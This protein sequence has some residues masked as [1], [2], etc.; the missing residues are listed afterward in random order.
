MSRAS[1]RKASSPELRPVL[2]IW[3]KKKSAISVISDIDDTIKITEI[4]AGPKVVVWNT[5]FR[6]FAAASGM[7]TMYQQELGA[8]A[9]H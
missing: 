9:F 7:A 1:W 8:A 3:S 6:D 2:A 5:F 4:P